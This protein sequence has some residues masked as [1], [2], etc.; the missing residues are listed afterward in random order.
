MG[1]GVGNPPNAKTIIK[2]KK[3]IFMYMSVCILY[4]VFCILYSPGYFRSRNVTKVLEHCQTLD[5]K[6]D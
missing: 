5:W 4:F 2:N 1:C 3:N 6:K